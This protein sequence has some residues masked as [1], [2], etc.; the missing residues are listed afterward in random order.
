MSEDVDVIVVGAGVAGLAAATTLRAAGRRVAVLE[1]APRIGGRAWTLA[2]P[3]HAFD[4]GASWLHDAD[5]NPLTPLA[6]QAGLPQT[7]TANTR[8][9]LLFDGRGTVDDAAFA[10]A[11]AAFEAACTRAAEAADPSVAE[12]IAPLMDDPWMATVENWEAAQIAAADPARLSVRDWRDNALD[13]RNLHVAGGIGA[14]VARV[15]ATEVATGTPVTALDWSGPGVRA[16]TPRGS[17]RAQA[18]I[19]TVSTGVLAAEAIRFTP[20]LPLAT[21]RAIAALPM[22]LL[23]KVALRLAAPESLPVPPNSVARRRLTRR[24]EPAMSFQLRPDASPLAIGFVGGP[25][26]WRLAAEAEA[27]SAAFAAD[28]LARLFGPLATTTAFVTRWGTDP[29]HRG[30]Y[31]YATPGN[32]GARAALGA[33]LEAGRLVFAGEATATDGLAGTVGGA[34][35]EGVR[36]ARAVMPAAP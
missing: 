35:N 32:A 29:L 17:L 21:L 13:G 25:T 34:F 36:A 20:T 14:L 7:D 6:E 10:R 30:A 26:A 8:T 5:R 9:R 1:A 4:A 16:H 12:A 24:G 22:G 2:L 27:E 28:Q 3:G 33:P 31:A 18:A 15:L 19:V 11:A 23:S